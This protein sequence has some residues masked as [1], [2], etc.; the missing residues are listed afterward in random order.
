MKTLIIGGAGYIGSHVVL[1]FCNRGKEVIV[2]DNLS[3]GHLSNV[4]SR[5][6]FIEGSI[7]N[8]SELNSAFE[9]I[10][11]KTVI[12][13][14]AL[15]AASESMIDPMKY[16]EMNICGSINVLNMMVK[17]NVKNIIFSSTAAVYGEP[18][19]LPI[20]ELHHLNPVNYY[21]FTKKSIEEYIQWYGELKGMRYSILR[22]FNA[23]GYDVNGQITGLEKN[24]QNLLPI[25]ME[26]L[27]GERD[28]LE[29]YGSDYN[30]ND[31]TCERDYIHVSDLAKA[32]YLS[33]QKLNTNSKNLIMNLA[34][35]EKYSVLDVI[36][37]CESYLG[38]KVNYKFVGRRM[39]DPEVLY[40]ESKLANNKLNWS[41]EH[42]D[43]ETILKSMYNVYNKTEIGCSL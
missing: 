16:S 25:V 30:T 42:S 38:K 40:S 31:G 12:H 26:V 34:T 3:T 28:Y 23:A 4:D 19:Y 37:G 22:Y 7:L 27:K 32:H 43:L 24:P 1:E 35:G 9:K 6:E 13:L 20:N 10:K 33:D 11:P 36:N 29:I 2:F 8:Q 5:A 39:G 21:G 15:K 17:H 41:P 18:K 14:A